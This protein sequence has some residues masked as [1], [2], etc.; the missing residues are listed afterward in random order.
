MAKSKRK[1]GKRRENRHEAR[2]ATHTGGTSAEWDAIRLPEGIEVFKPEAGETYHIDIIPYIVGKHNKHAPPGDEY[3]ELSYAVYNNIG[4]DEKRYVAIGEQTGSAD[5]VVEHFATLRRAGAEWEDMKNFKPKWRQLWLFYV[6]EQ[7]DKGLQ[8][9]EGAFGTFGELFEEELAAEDEEW[10]DNFDDPD[11]G[12]TLRVKFKS[13][14]IGMAN[15]WVHASSIKFQK[16]DN[17]FEGPEDVLEKAATICLEDCLKLETYDTLKAALEGRPTETEAA[18]GSGSIVESEPTTAVADEEAPWDTEEPE[19]PPTK[20]APKA[21]AK[22]WVKTKP[23][24]KA[25]AK[26]VS[27]EAPETVATT[28]GDGDDDWDEDWD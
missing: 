28:A 1:R 9:F 7:A 27:E 6:H 17:G 18:P 23:K 8:L 26:P 3:F 5:P 14:N 25:K 13:K 12:A 21:K 20:P 24:V 2:Q 4:I 16:R 11:A 15:L 10:V 19:E 22:P